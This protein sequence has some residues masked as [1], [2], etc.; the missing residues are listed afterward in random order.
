ML[1]MLRIFIFNN[2]WKKVEFMT[3]QSR[4]D[5]PVLLAGNLLVACFLLGSCVEPDKQAQPIH[6]MEGDKGLEEPVDEQGFQQEIGAMEE[7]AASEIDNEGKVGE[8]TSHEIQEQLL[9]LLQEEK[10]KGVFLQLKD[11]AE[12]DVPSDDFNEPQV[13]HAVL[14]KHD[15][16]MNYAWLEINEVNSKFNEA[17]QKHWG[18]LVTGPEILDEE[19][20]SN[21]LTSIQGK[22]ESLLSDIRLMEFKSSTEHAQHLHDYKLYLEG[23][24]LYRI[25]AVSHLLEALETQSQTDLLVEEAAAAAIDSESYA[26]LADSELAS[27]EQSF[28]KDPR[29]NLE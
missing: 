26:E 2:L 14:S 28:R 3:R 21:H 25:E 23:A 24:V 22:Y 6:F 7:E 8:V 18:I 27:Y 13:A 12:I 15:F 4:C 17:W 16:S 11:P 1:V 10:W 5:V 20:L 29:W 19:S 9:L